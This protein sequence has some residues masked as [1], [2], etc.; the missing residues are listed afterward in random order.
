MSILAVSCGF[1]LRGST[2][3]AETELSRLYL[4]ETGTSPVTDELRYMLE[5]NGTTIVEERSQAEY[6]LSLENYNIEQ[7]VL[8]VSPITG[9]AEEYQLQ[10]SV[11]VTL[12]GRDNKEIISNRLIRITRDYAFDDTAVLG[13]VTERDVLLNEMAKL[14]AAQIV[15]ALNSLH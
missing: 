2:P 4:A 11:R 7:T 15:Q 14:A 1:H 13:S 8:S 10:I 9:K 12:S 6:R 5:I 3:R